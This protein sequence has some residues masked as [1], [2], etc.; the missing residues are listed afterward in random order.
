MGRERYEVRLTES[1]LSDLDEIDD[2]WFA[3]GEPDRGIQYVADLIRKA[4]SELAEPTV[5]R[6][7][8]DSRVALL[9][10]TREMLV[11]K[12]SYRI[13]FRIDHAI[14]VVHVLRFWHSHRDEPS[15][16]DLE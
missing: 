6:K 10:N 7:S 16:E 9:P 4:E 12:A 13:I 11:F 1:A 2:Y 5:L 15:I 8:R 14:G 3:R